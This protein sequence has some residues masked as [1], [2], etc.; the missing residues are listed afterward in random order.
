MGLTLDKA[1]KEVLGTATRVMVTK[2]STLIVT[3]GSTR[4]AVDKRVSE[5]R[6]LAEVLPISSIY[7]VLVHFAFWSQ[8][9]LQC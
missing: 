5:I 9:K 1:G 8:H 3:D 7:V 4:A 6:S 2:D